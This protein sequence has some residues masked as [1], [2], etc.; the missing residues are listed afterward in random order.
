VAP[1][2]V[3]SHGPRRLLAVVL[4]PGIEAATLTWA[5]PS[6]ALVALATGMACSTT[7]LFGL[8]PAWVAWRV[9]PAADLQSNRT[10]GHTGRLAGKRLAHGIVALEIAGALV[11]LAGAGLLA[12][13]VARYVAFD[14]GFRT[15]RLVTVAV[16]PVIDSAEAADV[17][18][19]VEVTWQQLAGLPG[20]QAATVACGPRPGRAATHP[21]Q[22]TCATYN[23]AATAHASQ[24]NGGG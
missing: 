4:S 12:R 22:R 3:S 15:D 9:A 24:R 23:L 10:L 21:R 6:V 7:I 16:A 13:T 18:A 17:S 11:L 5:W 8:A 14:P 19:A 20:V 1:P 2:A